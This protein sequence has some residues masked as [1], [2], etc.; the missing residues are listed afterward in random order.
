MTR[1]SPK[2]IVVALVV[3][4]LVVVVLFVSWWVVR[5][6]LYS[7][8]TVSIDRVDV[9]CSKRPLRRE[10][11]FRPPRQWSSDCDALRR[12][13][14]RSD[15]SEDRF[16]SFAYTSPADGKNY[17]GILQRSLNDRSQAARIGDRI[18][19][20]ASR[21]MPE[22]FTDWSSPSIAPENVIRPPAAAR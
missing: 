15:V 18:E 14:G 11:P 2:A 20:E 4:V 16:I 3:M 5:I 17:R 13:F 21:L 22:T 1:S 12:Q 6:A 9:L 10:L 19:I 7:P 8:Q